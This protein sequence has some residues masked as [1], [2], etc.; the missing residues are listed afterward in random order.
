MPLIGK[1]TP[2]GLEIRRPILKEVFRPPLDAGVIL[3]KAI[4]GGSIFS[5]AQPARKTNK[6]VASSVFILFVTH[7]CFFVGNNWRVKCIGE[8]KAM[9]VPRTGYATARTWPS[10]P[11]YPLQG[12]KNGCERTMTFF[13]G[14]KIRAPAPDFPPWVVSALLRSTSRAPPR[15][16]H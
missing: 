4:C 2:L 9:G 14:R 3:V 11:Y 8:E 15:K 10:R 1:L 6:L 7:R 13:S 12:I 5:V 16:W